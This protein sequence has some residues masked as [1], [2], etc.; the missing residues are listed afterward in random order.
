[1]VKEKYLQQIKKNVN[2]T[3]TDKNL[4]V[5][6]FGSGLRKNRF[7][8]IDLGFLG[9]IKKSSVCKLKEKFEESTFP[10]KVDIVNFNKVSKQFKDNI[11]EDK[12]LWIK[13]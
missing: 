4:Q 8:D 7:G 10:Y 9:K 13:R 6:V 3:I 1:M 2:E 12:I 11:L 5:F